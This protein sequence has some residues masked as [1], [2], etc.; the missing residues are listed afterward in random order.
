MARGSSGESGRGSAGWQLCSVPCHTDDV[1]DG[2]CLRDASENARDAGKPSGEGGMR[3]TGET[4]AEQVE[5]EE[6]EQK[7]DTEWP[8]GLRRPPCVRPTLPFP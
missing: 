7:H 5:N 3:R 6:E 1:L 2:V 8:R 4:E